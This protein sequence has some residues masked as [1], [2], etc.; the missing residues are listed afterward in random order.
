MPELTPQNSPLLNHA[1][2]VGDRLFVDGRRLRLLRLPDLRQVAAGEDGEKAVRHAGNGIFVLSKSLAS[3]R[4]G[5]SLRCTLSPHAHR[6]GIFPSASRPPTFSP[7]D[8]ENP[9][10]HPAEM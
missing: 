7:A 3:S 6:R 1:R 2:E 5:L 9:P 4:S 10:A 8:G